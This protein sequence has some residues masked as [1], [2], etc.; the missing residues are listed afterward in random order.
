[1]PTFFQTDT[2]TVRVGCHIVYET[3]APT[4][5]LLNESYRAESKCIKCDTCD[6]YPCL[7]HAKADAEVIAVRTQADAPRAQPSVSAVSGASSGR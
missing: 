2:L 4:A 5:V 1:M 7:V 3:S 6:G